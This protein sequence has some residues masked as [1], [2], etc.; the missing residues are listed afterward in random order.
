MFKNMKLGTKIA[1]GFG[2]LIVILALLG[3]TGWLAINNINKQL[4]SFAEWGNVDASM[5]EDVIQAFLHLN[6]DLTEYTTKKDAEY[7]ETVNKELDN[8]KN[9]IKTWTSLDTVQG[10][11]E[12]ESVAAK[13]NQTFKIYN[14]NIEELST[15]L[16]RQLG[17]ITAWDSI[18]SETLAFLETTMEEIIDPAKEAA[19]ESRDIAAMIKWSNIDMHMNEDV[20]ANFLMLQT[21]SH[22][23]AAKPT[24]ESW[25]KLLEVDKAVED[26]LVEWQKTL[27]GEKEMEN[28]AREISK[29][30]SD[31]D[32]KSQEYQEL[33]ISIEETI[34][35]LETAEAELDEIFDNTMENVIDPAKDSA[36]EKA[37]ASQK[38][39]AIL[40]LV[41]TIVGI[42][43]GIIL[44]F[45][46]TKSITKPINRVIEGMTTGSEQVATASNQVSQS[47]QQMAEGANEQAS[48]LEEISS[49]LEEMTSMT[50]QNA[51]NA[52]QANN[53][54]GEA[55]GAA[56]NGKGA[57]T[58]MSSAIDKIKTSSD[59]TAKI[60]KTIDEIAFQTNLLAL[61]A[62]VEAARAGEAGKGFAVVAEEVRNLAQRSAE[63]AKNTAELIEESQKNSEEGVSVT[64]EVGEILEQIAG[65]AEKVAN[66]IAEVS[67]ASNEQAQGIEQV[68]TA[69]AQMDKV[70][71]SNAANAEESASAS[72]ELSAQARELNDM[73]GD[74]VA[75]VGGSKGQVKMREVKESNVQRK[76]NQN[77]HQHVF[78]LHK[79]DGKAERVLA[80]IRKPVHQGK[81]VEPEEIIPLEEDDDFSNF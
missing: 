69:V 19:E 55:Q 48:S 72:E 68:N 33:V 31:Y 39:G 15:G 73:V 21:A 74:L 65:S 5:N 4:K 37:E 70:T 50:R 59:E 53:L 64:G 23:Y 13:M 76:D 56:T 51:D 42:V 12:L 10:N 2:S 62:A 71:Q 78:N 57:M 18:I 32:A 60:I 16:N 44:A 34:K 30:L 47:S 29:F 40:S 24:E 75:I 36:V 67:A 81:I 7:L 63:A 35:D 17:L 49:S 3:F 1:V 80:S 45:F 8:V 26:G 14:D 9:G 6:H 58:R 27:A 22:D 46:I 77:L 11:K 52:K 20:I 43:L 28:R 25:N 61:N 79:R 38:T 66:L 41:F 54:A